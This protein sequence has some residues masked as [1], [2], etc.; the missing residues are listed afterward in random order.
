MDIKYRLSQLFL[1]LFISFQGLFAQENQKF[2]LNK[3]LDFHSIQKEVAYLHLNKSLLLQGEQLGVSAYVL[4]PNGFKSSTKTTNL[5]VQIKDADNVVIKEKMLLIENGTGAST[6]DI[7]STFISGSYS[8]YAFTNWM[9]NFDQQYFFQEEIQVLRSNLENEPTTP[10]NVMIDAQFLPESGHLIKDRRNNLGI[11][12]KNHQ[13]Y[14][15]A[16]ASVRILTN[17]N[18][19]VGNTKLNRFGIGKI[20]FIPSI[21]ETYK[22]LINYKGETF[23]EEI[24]VKTDSK[25]I[26]INTKFDE[27]KVEVSLITNL[28]TMESV[29]NTPYI[30]CVQ[31]SYGAITYEVNFQGVQN[32]VIPFSYQDLKPGINI[33]TLFN[34]DKKPVAERLF[35]NYKNLS[36]AELGDPMIKKRNDTLQVTLPTNKFADSTFLSVSI[37]PKN[38]IAK[39]RNHNIVSYTLLQPYVNGSIE[40]GDWYF[41]DIDT[42][43]KFA[44]DNLLLT[45]GWSSYD[46]RKIFKRSNEFLFSFERYVDLKAKINNRKEKDEQFLIHASSTN[47]PTYIQIP[48]GKDS[49]IFEGVIPLEGENLFL[50]RVKKNGG[51]LPA[52]LSIQFFPH[53]INE[54]NPK[55]NSLS[56]KHTISSIKTDPYFF[57]LNKFGEEFEQLGEVLIKAKVDKKTIRERKL[58]EHSWGRVDVLEE[59]EKVMFNTLANYLTAQGFRVNESPTQFLG[60]S[61]LGSQGMDSKPDIGEDQTFSGLGSDKTGMYEAVPIVFIDDIPVYEPESLYQYS[62]ANVDYIEINKS[63]IGGGFNDAAIKIYTNYNRLNETQSNITRVQKFDFP[64]AYA[65]NKKFYIPKYQNTTDEFF[66]QYGVIDWKSNLFS[67]GSENINFEIAQPQVDFLMIIEGFTT[68]GDLIH[69]VETMSAK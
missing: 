12:I 18:K 15:L 58:N 46:W 53:H 11:V 41:K 5:Y 66:Q 56:Y 68:N 23:T 40:D 55:T 60:V 20:S 1:L 16:N 19:L 54:F 28:E 22:A 69:K 45:Q 2:L 33:F 29:G 10:S 59:V 37:L 36:I 47:K 38:S 32:I 63:G 24:L 17:N 44:L 65:L 14:G 52:G 43:K 26:I 57:N 25:G 67:S 34:K 61:S 8:I 7:D 51:L 4:N 30:F 39:N 27:E 35:F 21:S 6:F 48:E 9:R 42:E 50:S 62:L 49:F 31:S 64:L 3:L 13:G